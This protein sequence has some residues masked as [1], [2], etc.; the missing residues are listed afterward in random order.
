MSK[1]FVALI[2]AFFMLVTVMPTVAFAVGSATL[3]VTSNKNSVTPGD[4]ITV[5][6][7]LSGDAQAYSLQAKLRYDT[8]KVAYAAGSAKL[9]LTQ[10]GGSATINDQVSGEISVNTMSS[11]TDGAIKTGSIMEAQFTVLESATGKVVFEL[12]DSFTEL[13]A[14]VSESFANI[15]T[16]DIP[17][18][19]G[20]EIPATGITLPETVTVVRGSTTQLTPSSPRKTPPARWHGPPATLR[21]RP[22]TKVAL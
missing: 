19:V 14:G 7:L 2:L 12:D 5:T 21:L 9:T 22:W 17:A 13:T 15:P 20:I 4:T 1:K 6:V 11:A 16:I 3:T 8:T 18:E 10:T